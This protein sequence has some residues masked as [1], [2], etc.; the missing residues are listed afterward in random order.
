[1]NDFEMAIKDRV[2]LVAGV[3]AQGRSDDWDFPT[4]KLP[5]I[6]WLGRVHRGTPWQT[7]YLKS[8]LA[9]D[10][11]LKKQTRALTPQEWA[12]WSG[13]FGTHPTNDW[14]FLDL[15]T[16]FR[17]LT[18]GLPTPCG[19]GLL[20]ALVYFALDAM[21]AQEKD[22]MRDLAIRGGPWKPEEKAA[23]LVYCES[24]VVALE[25]LLPKMAPTLDVERA[26]LR[27]RYMTAAARMESPA[28]GSTRRR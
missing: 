18:N 10:D 1:M 26:L 24:D 8:H 12:A 9:F 11:A 2:A 14:K 4:N 3:K 27:G 20:G 21:A 6:G 19:R 28:H 23:L 7:I 17:N 5:N 13:S 16:E 15:F 25:R 22:T